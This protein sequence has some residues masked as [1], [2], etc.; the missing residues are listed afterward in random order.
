MMEA[1]YLDIDGTLRDERFGIPQSAKWALAQCRKEK[2]KNIICTGRNLASIQKD[3]KELPIDGIISGG[4]CYIHYHGEVLWERYFLP[5]VIE[6]TIEQAVQHQIALSMEA[7]WKIY[8]DSYAVTFYQKDLERKVSGLSEPA[9]RMFFSD[10]KIQYRDNFKEFYE[11]KPKVHK[12]CMMGERRKIEN[13][14]ALIETEI[15]IVQEKEWQDLWYLEVLPKKCN[16]GYAMRKLN[17]M[18]GISA[19]H[20]ICFGDS[21]NDIPMMQESKIA[22]AMGCCS[23]ILEKYATSICETITEDGIYKELIRRHVIK[24]I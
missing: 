19:E 9:K 2:I 13:V 6:F 16:K 3:V 11:D 17:Q 10:N 5:E 23:P 7:K 24:Q 21:E 18:A 12:I 20:T 15:E 1:I 4:G 14:K 22:V 8:M